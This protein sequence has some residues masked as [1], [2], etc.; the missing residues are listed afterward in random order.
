MITGIVRGDTIILEADI[1]SDITDWKIR[2]ELTDDHGN[3]IKLGTT[4]VTGGS[5]DQIEI[6]SITANKSTFL[7]KIPSGKT[8][9][10]ADKAEIEIQVTTLNI[11]NNAPEICTVF[12]GDVDFNKQ[13]ITWETL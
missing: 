4:N 2:F 12:K 3:C 1:A 11:V 7:I 10:F 9:C 5:D 13:I 6:T 8:D